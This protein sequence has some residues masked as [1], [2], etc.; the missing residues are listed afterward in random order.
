MCL[1]KKIKEIY[2]NMN[3]PYHNSIGSLKNQYIHVIDIFLPASCVTQSL[4]NYS[5]SYITLIMKF[6][7]LN[8]FF[9]K[10]SELLN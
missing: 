3:I 6:G 7:V 4:L 5:L 8:L 1:I 10:N 2:Y 9:C